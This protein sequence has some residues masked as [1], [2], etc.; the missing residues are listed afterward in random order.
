MAQHAVRESSLRIR[1][2]AL[3]DLLFKDLADEDRDSL[4]QLCRLLSAIFHFEYHDRLAEL[5]AAYEP[6]DPDPDAEGR[7]GPDAE[8][9][10]LDELFARFIQL[11]ERANFKRLSRDQIQE[12]VHGGAS[13]WGV[14]MEV[15]FDAFDRLEVF[16]C[17]DTLGKRYRRRLRNWWRVEEVAV[18][19]YQRLVL[20]LKLK[21]HE[22]LD[23]A[24]DT[25]HVYVKLFK[26]IPKIDLEMLLPGTRLSMPVV[27][28]LKLGGSLMSSIGF[29]LWKIAA[30]AQHLLGAVLQHRPLVFWGPISLMLGYGYKQYQGFQTTKQ[31]YSLML[32]QS[33]YYQNLDN[34]IGVFTRLLDVA[35][36]QECHEAILA[37]FFLW[38]H[39]GEHGWTRAALDD[40]IEAFL[41]GS[42]GMKVDFEIDDAMS[43]LER[44]GL[45]HKT[46]DRYRAVSV[47]SALERLDEIWDNY[48]KYHNERACRRAG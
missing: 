44:L 5:K 27:E 18:P 45:V 37:Y 41:E 29:V 8:P 9:P 30:E 38:R 7:P 28:R 12:A 20:I 26:D 34:N 25:Q 43:K 21:K 6:F 35:E 46:G 10:V 17:G 1:A 22:R 16:A 14:N 23:P 39:A 47:V 2:R 13:D 33:L 48:F 3:L 11:M 19:I 31:S 32:T 40:A 42:A 15:D 36:A 24:V 4:R